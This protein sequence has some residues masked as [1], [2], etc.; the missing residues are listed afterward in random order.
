MRIGD[1][2]GFEISEED[3][4]QEEGEMGRTKWQRLPVGFPQAV[5]FQM[6]AVR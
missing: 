2:F 3:F 4:E 5:S 1:R 6:P